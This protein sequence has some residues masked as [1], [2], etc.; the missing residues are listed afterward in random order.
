MKRIL[1]LLLALISTAAAT[2]AQT[3]GNAVDRDAIK[4][5]ATRWQDAWNRHDM[6]ALSEL[7]AEDVDFITVAGT[8]LTSR[9]AFH[10]HHAKRHEMQFKESIWTTGTTAVKFIKPDI[11]VAHVEWRMKNDRDPDGTPRR[12]RNGIFTWVLEKR[13]GKWVLVASQ[14]TN[15]NTAVPTK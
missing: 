9:K 11:A 1:I 3:S 5:I 6:T 2:T 7:V 15:I 13:K 10:D 4:S 8:W 14:N 12:P